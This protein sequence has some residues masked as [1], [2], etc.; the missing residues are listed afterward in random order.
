MTLKSCLR[1]T[2]PLI[3]CY[4]R[5]TQVEE[6][7]AIEIPVV[8]EFGDV[9]PEEK[10]GLPPKRDIVFSVELKFGTG[11]ISKAPYHMGLKELEELKK[12]LN[13]LLDKG[14]I[15]PSMRIFLRQLS[16]RGMVT[17][18]VVMPFELTNAP[19]MFMDLMNRIFSPFLDRKSVHSLCTAMSLMKLRDEMTKMGIQMIRTGDAIDGS[20][21]FDG[22]WCAPSDADLKKLI[23]TEAQSLFVGDKV[24]LKVSPM[25]GV[26]RFGKRGKLSE[27]F[28]GPYE[29]L[30]RVGEIAYR[31]TLPPSLDQVHNVFHVS[32][33]LKYVS[34]PSYVLEVENIE[35]DKALAYAEVPKKILDRKV[36]KTRNDETV[37]LKVLWSNHNVEEATW[38]PEE[39]M[40]ERYPHLF[41]QFP[42]KIDNGT[43]MSTPSLI[44]DVRDRKCN[45]YQIGQLDIRFAKLEASLLDF[46][47]RFTG[48]EKE[49]ELYRLELIL[50]SYVMEVEYYKL[51]VR[52]SVSMQCKHKSFLKLLSTVWYH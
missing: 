24:F 21:C 20:V 6:P 2:C 51:V 18:Y 50:L 41:E 49:D 26:M 36:C 37:L 29:I 44:N 8:S 11:L 30:G 4:V 12:Q 5:D 14:Y 1:K 7:S 19:K 38:E 13:E 40:R 9:F 33:L 22:R 32:Q 31:L 42:L 48:L 47:F 23:M 3:L 28:I 39:A 27:K 10:P 25:R 45:F 43:P 52:F 17:M 15:R 34:D 35:L 46:K 16:D